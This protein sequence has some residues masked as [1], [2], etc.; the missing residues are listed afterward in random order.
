[1]L[2]SLLFVIIISVLSANLF[3]QSHNGKP[4]KRLSSK[5]Y[6]EWKNIS[7]QQVSNDGSGFLMK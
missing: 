7:N 5:V 3:A 1:M 2:K 4:K 6:K